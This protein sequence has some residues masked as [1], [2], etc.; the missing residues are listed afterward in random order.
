MANYI[1]SKQCENIK[2]FYCYVAIYMLYIHVVDDERKSYNTTLRKDLL[3]KIRILA[4]LTDRKQNDLIE[5]ALL[6]L[7]KKYTKKSDK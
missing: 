1:N 4:A 3:K 6:D 5:E 7:L 2:L